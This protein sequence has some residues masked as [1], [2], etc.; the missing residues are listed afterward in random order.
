MVRPGSR[1]ECERYNAVGGESFS[2]GVPE[3]WQS[4]LWNYQLLKVSAAVL[5]VQR[6]KEECKGSGDDGA[7]E[8]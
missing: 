3:C 6:V 7:A 5:S 2:P 8:S 1:I 4:C